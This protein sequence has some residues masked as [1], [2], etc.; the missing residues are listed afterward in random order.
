MNN[1][2]LTGL[3]DTL[4]DAPMKRKLRRLA[5]MPIGCVFIQ[6][7]TMSE[8]D[9]R[10]QFRAI[11][12]TGFTC[13]KGLM[14]VPGTSLARLQHIAIEEGL[15]PWWYD[16]GGWEDITPELLAK[17][18]LPATMDV[19]EAMA[20]PQMVEYQT[21]L[22]HERVD[23]QAANEKKRK[24]HGNPFL[25]G[26]QDPDAVPGVNKLSR[27]TELTAAE[28]PHF[29]GWLQ[30]NYADVESLK[31]AWNAYSGS[32]SREAAAWQTWEDVAGGLMEFPQREFRHLRDILRFK[33]DA[34]LAR[35]RQAT[36]AA[37]A[38]DPNEP[39]RA[40]G[41][42]SI[43]LPHTASAIDMEGYAEVMVE[44]GCFYPSMHP[45]WHLEEVEFELVR[46][47]YMQA[48]MC[49]DWAKGNWSA[50]I[51]SSGGPQWW[52]GGGK[53]PFVPE[54]KPLQPAFTFDGGTM[55]QLICSYLGAGFKGF[56][57]W[58]W[59]PREASWEAGEYALCDRNNELTP[60]ARRV[61]EF[62]RAMVRYRRELWQAR[63]EPLVGLFQ[64]WENDA[65]W[66][67][68]ATSGRDRYKNEP[69]KARIGAA[70]ALI[71]AN[72]PWEH[73]TFRQL[74]KG[75]APRYRVLYLPAVISLSPR[76]LDILTGYVQQGGR[77]VLDM[78]GAWLDETGHLIATQPGSAFEKLF[79]VVLHEYAYANNQ[80]FALGDL[81]LKGF[82][83][84]LTP[85]TARVVAPYQNGRPGI[86]ENRLGTG[87]A[88]VLGA[89]AALQCLKPGNT[90]LERLLVQ[91]ALGGMESPYACD[92]AIVYRL[93]SPAAD[94]YFLINDGPAR[95][96]TLDTKAHRYTSQ[97]DAVTGEAVAGKIAL[98]AHDARW[99][100]MTR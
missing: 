93:A 88:V 20:H 47:T 67:A 3:H 16:Q 44:G 70:R 17:L 19:D 36:R 48:A 78:P 62:G 32:H 74:D 5:P 22:M 10:R 71:N 56:G 55:A 73:V 65:M 26:D 69:T 1:S 100:R 87:T 85:T 15:S 23:R 25:P 97:H 42:M 51:E 27:G 43:F 89:E 11:K 12:A 96:V 82:T 80:P 21:K 76:L 50:P 49:A 77:V 94:H 40:G 30:R 53:V 6:W 60:R 79:G 63:K 39:V 90:A 9:V 31:R 29:V 38:A 98:P 84:V 92:G 83:A 45:G 75:L 35:V 95:E 41:E 81:A 14:A 59:N 57:L 52:S 46:P 72:V 68:L 99:I 4:H 13:L 61:G 91:T 64:D 7:P 66:A 58:C 24:G 2:F 18:G 28:A 37:H 54:V 86:T 33:A 34:K 8:E